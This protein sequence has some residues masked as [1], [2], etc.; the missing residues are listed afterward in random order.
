MRGWQYDVAL[1]QFGRTIDCARGDQRCFAARAKR[2][3]RLRR[4]AAQ[5]L[6][7]LRFRINLFL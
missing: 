1:F 3:S 4:N 7:I 5:L 2:S 6:R